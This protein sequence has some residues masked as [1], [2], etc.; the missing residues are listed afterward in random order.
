MLVK[1]SEW[2]QN[3]DVEPMKLSWY[4]RMLIG[5]MES[6][7]GAKRLHDLVTDT[8]FNI[9]QMIVIFKQCITIL[10]NDT[11]CEEEMLDDMLICFTKIS[12]HY[13]DSVLEEIS[14]L[15]N[16]EMYDNLDVIG[17]IA[18]L[19]INSVVEEFIIQKTELCKKS[20]TR[21]DILPTL[22]YGYRKYDAKNPALG[23]PAFVLSVL[24]IDRNEF[25]E[26]TREKL[27]EIFEQV[28]PADWVAIVLDSYVRTYKDM[29][30]FGI[31]AEN[32]VP[33]SLQE[34]FL[35]NP[36]ST[37][38]E[39]IVGVFAFNFGKIARPSVI[40][41]YDEDDIPTFDDADAY[42]EYID[43]DEAAS[44]AGDRELVTQVLVDFMRATHIELN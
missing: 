28:G 17:K 42:L 2:S 30:E 13:T 18:I 44:G 15:D 35:T 21:A 4:L 6:E 22:V 37:V 32:H 34:D 26:E 31:D 12:Q 16:G 3:F 7:H 20:G 1:P 8:E 38:K 19:T 10:E 14:D 40:Y 41:T 29:D 24:D 9:N 23:K 27:N 39:A 36:N 5:V 25:A 11:E 33:G 43:Y